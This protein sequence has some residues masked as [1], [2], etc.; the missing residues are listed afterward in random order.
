MVVLDRWRLGGYEVGRSQR[1]DAG[2]PR[3]GLWALVEPSHDPIDIH[4]GGG[5]PVLSVR[6][7]QPPIP[8]V[9]QPTGAHAWR[10]GPFAAGSPCLA[11]L[12][13]RAGIPR[14]RGLQRLIWRLRM[15]LQGARRLGRLRA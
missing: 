3:L 12:P 1:R 5:G 15:E 10:E 7:W 4:G 14:S 11:W 6:L 9:P 2:Y 13:L 8:R